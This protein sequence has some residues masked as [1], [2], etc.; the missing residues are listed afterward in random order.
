MYDFVVKRLYKIS[1]LE[2]SDE[3]LLDTYEDILAEI[4]VFL[5]EACEWP[6]PYGSKVKQFVE[7]LQQEEEEE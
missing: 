7:T 2:E 3:N 6:D 1:G 5:G 4:E